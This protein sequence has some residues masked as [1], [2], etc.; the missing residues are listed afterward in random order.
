MS[1]QQNKVERQK[2]LIIVTKKHFALT[3]IC[4]IGLSLLMYCLKFGTTGNRTYLI[5]YVFI[6]G[7][8]SIQQRLP[9]TD[10]I[11]SSAKQRRKHPDR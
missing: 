3:V 10:I 2:L 8:V 1:E 6:A 5:I 11:R 7:F 4:L 9:K